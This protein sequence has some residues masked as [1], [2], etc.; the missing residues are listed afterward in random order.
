MQI[1]NGSASSNVP[2]EAVAKWRFDPPRRHHRCRC[3]GWDHQMKWASTHDT[4]CTLWICIRVEVV[5]VS[6]TER[7]PTSLVNIW[8]CTSR[9]IPVPN[10]D[11]RPQEDQTI[12]TRIQAASVRVRVG[13]RNLLYSMCT[14]MFWCPRL[15]YLDLWDGY[16]ALNYT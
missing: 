13:V 11:Q 14:F 5:T 8:S 3:S 2:M 9:C 7:L 6:G 4:T 10:T 1:S 12:G 16:M 15:W